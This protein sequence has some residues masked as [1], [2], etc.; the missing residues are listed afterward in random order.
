MPLSEYERQVLPFNLHVEMVPEDADAKTMAEVMSLLQAI[1]DDGEAY[2]LIGEHLADTEDEE[3]T[4]PAEGDNAILIREMKID[5][6]GI[7]TIL[8]HHGD[9]DAADPAL[10]QIKSGKIRNA[11]KKEDEGV[12]HAAHLLIS[13]E[14]HISVSGQSR[15]LLERVP[16][17]GRS[18]V[19]AFLNRLLRLRAKRDHMEFK[20]KST[21]RP[22]R[23]HPKLVSQQQLSPHLRADLEEGKLSS[24]ELVTRH[25]TDG[26]EE[27]NLIVPVTRTIVH[28]VVN[29]PTGK[30]AFDLIERAK[31]WAKR[32]HF[33]EMQLH[34]RKT[35][36]AQYLS[37]RFATDLADAKDAVY[38]RFEVISEFRS[39]L[40]QCPTA[41]VNELRAKMGGLHPV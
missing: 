6:D 41:I 21:K 1:Y 15:A 10:M 33:E 13:T 40:A 22:K 34:F 16:N 7:A 3:D 32:H 18:T 31:T 14:K 25:V 30:R 17:L 20:D 12:A 27:Q 28:K 8:L 9:A 29:A 23:C 36:T 19:I 37:P 26:F 39:P 35:T 24:I 11:G 5:R 38:S 4:E 2:V